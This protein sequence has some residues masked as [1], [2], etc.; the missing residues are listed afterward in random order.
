MK[1]TTHEFSLGRYGLQ[2]GRTVEWKKDENAG[3]PQSAETIPQTSRE[4][5]SKFGRRSSSE[6]S[7]V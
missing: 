1:I 3:G 2:Y 4:I 6:R 7:M 5:L